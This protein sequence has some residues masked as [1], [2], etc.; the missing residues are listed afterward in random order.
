FIFILRNQELFDE[1]ILEELIKKTN[2]FT[3]LAGKAF[4]NLLFEILNYKKEY[5]KNL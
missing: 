2:K 5:F 1:K 3:S 4:Q